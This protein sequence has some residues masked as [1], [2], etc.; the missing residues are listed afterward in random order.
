MATAALIIASI[1]SAT[2]SV[3]SGI[4]QK[5]AAENEAELVEQQGRL[6]QEE[7]DLNAI[8]QSTENRRF[9][10]K[11]KLAFLSSGVSLEGSPL[12]L[13]EETRVESATEVAAIRRKGIAQRNL[14]LARAQLLRNQ[15][16]AAFIGG[17]VG[18]VG[19]L[20]SG[21]F[22]GAEAG[23]FG[24]GGGTDLGFSSVGSRASF[25]NTAPHNVP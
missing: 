5:R 13:L 1:A 12:L 20:A 4:Q 16:R 25:S 23:L 10:K 9:R 19:S 11:Q 8:R 21:A 2:S 15:G 14:A 18:G 22:A 24:G 7:A 3:V 17:I 6:A